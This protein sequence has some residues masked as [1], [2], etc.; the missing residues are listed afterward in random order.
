MMEMTAT[1]F[2]MLLVEDNPG[3][4]VLVREALERLNLGVRM[5]LAV[6]GSKA[7]EFLQGPHG[8]QLDVVVLD[9]NLPIKNGQEVLAEM[10][11]DER[12]N[13]LPVAILTTSND[14]NDAAARRSR[15]KCLFFTKTP[16]MS[17][18]VRIMAEIHTF[19]GTGK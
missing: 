6:D 5:H 9:L 1:Q 2:E 19:A 8:R 7:L 17:E 14:E 10:N 13:S 3:D 18:L 12:L 4:V 16:D 11:A 15:E